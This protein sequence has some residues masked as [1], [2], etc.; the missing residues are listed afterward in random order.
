MNWNQQVRP[1]SSESHS[2]HA[3]CRE[4]SMVRI[5]TVCTRTG[6][7]KSQVQRLVKA[8]DFPRPV[9][10]S[11]RAVAWVSQEV[12]DWLRQRIQTSRPPV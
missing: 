2:D 10:L 4:I 1:L 12:D 6:L 8:D 9:A 7:S 11:K 3:R 5:N